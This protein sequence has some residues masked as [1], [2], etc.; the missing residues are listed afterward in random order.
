MEHYKIEVA[1]ER[2]PDTWR[3]YFIYASLYK[4]HSSEHCD[5]YKLF[6]PTA[7]YLDVILKSYENRYYR[8]R[9][10]GNGSA[11]D[12]R[13]DV[14]VSYIKQYGVTIPMRGHLPS[15]LEKVHA[16]VKLTGSASSAD[17]IA[18]AN[19][20]AKAFQLLSQETLDFQNLNIT[21][22]KRVYT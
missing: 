7:S 5:C 2:M 8:Y 22:V 19:A 15:T 21:Q 3:C 9:W 1:P 11:N 13:N 14:R 4:F 17:R 18:D 16:G 6:S 12:N 10:S 20:A